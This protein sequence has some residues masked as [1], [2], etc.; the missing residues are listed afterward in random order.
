DG[1]AGAGLAGRAGPGPAGAVRGAPGAGEHHDPGRGG[2]T[3]GGANRARGGVAVIE[4]AACADQ[5]KAW[6][7]RM[8]QAL[9]ERLPA[10]DIEPTPLHAAMRYCVLHGAPP[11]RP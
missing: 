8:E 3:S 5:V 4:R 1:V 10:T 6:Q 2:E 11:L 7:G 9:A